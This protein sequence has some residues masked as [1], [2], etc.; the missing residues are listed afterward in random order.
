MWSL[1]GH[2]STKAQQPIS[3]IEEG[4]VLSSIRV[5]VVEDHGDWRR[6]VRLLLEARPDLHIVCEVADGRDAIAKAEEL[7]P[8]L[9]LLDIG[10]PTLSGL[11]AAPEIRRVSPNSK[12]LFLTQNN[13]PELVQA[14]LGAGALGC[15]HK[16]YAVRE[17]LHAVDAVL[18]NE[19]FF[20]SS[21]IAYEFP[22]A[23]PA[24]SRRH[25]VEFYIGDRAF[26][27]GLARFISVAL[28]GGNAAILIATKSHF[29]GIIKSLDTQRVDIGLA[30]N[31]RS[32]IAL[33]TRETLASFMVDGALDDGR[34]LE[35]AGRLVEEAG[36]TARGIR[37][38]VAVCG[39]CASVL[40]AQG[41]ADAAIR[42]EH[43]FEQ[44]T[45][46]H[47]VDVLCGYDL[48]VVRRLRGKQVFRRICAEHSAFR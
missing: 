29:D 26:M 45:K 21:L 10:L 48:N 37:P 8:E 40:W 17:L 9:I 20:S 41:K 24:K 32:F 27:E 38:C 44:L 31:S 33:N 25:E 39:D 22:E 14:A 16:L 1:N 12:I 11:E 4:R 47:D 28:E 23:P 36:R 18:R 15:V 3:K 43:L 7:N 13:S 30:M 5:L 19:Q 2:K 42:L 34:F 46:T 6:Q 35:I